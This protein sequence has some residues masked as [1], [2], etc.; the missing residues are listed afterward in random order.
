MIRSSDTMT[1]SAL[2]GRRVG[3]PLKALALL[4]VGVIALH[5]LVLHGLAQAL[6]AVQPAFASGPVFTTRT[7][8]LEA[9]RAPEAPRTVPEP[10]Q[11]NAHPPQEPLPAAVQTPQARP[12]E[13]PSRETPAAEPVVLQ[14]VSDPIPVTVLAQRAAEAPASGQTPAIA[15]GA[16]PL[17]A[18]GGAVTAS[19][20]QPD[21]DYQ[22]PGSSRLK[23]KGTG[24]K[25][26]LS[27]PVAAEL[28]WSREGR[29]YDARLEL[30]L[31]GFARV[32]TSK[33]V[34]GPRGLEPLRFGD[35]TRSEEAA[36][37]QRAK[38]IV[39]FSAN[40]PD[41][42]LMP[43]A[44]DLL[45]IYVQLASM[46][47]ANPQRFRPGMQLPFQL[48]EKHR[49]GNRVFTVGA[50]ERLKVEGRE[51]VATRLVC[52]PSAD[53]DNR[54]EVW[55]A[56]ALEYLPARIRMTQANGDEVDIFWSSSEK[57]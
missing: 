16:N 52:D 47:S 10:T 27:L 5:A 41:A 56:P 44:Q 31:L 4:V 2:P 50:T 30:G 33:G 20:G 51:M 54:V 21:Y 19:A 6:A 29:A 17:P 14:E 46:W 35:K 34:V 13:T 18:G 15:P 24:T 8:V 45:S 48:V 9:P 49:S 42:P 25:G 39:S 11:P 53:Y 40:G 57:P 23:Y 36:H 12:P 26:F 28:L 43:L 7:V 3:S 37:F 55:L 38:G 32:Q 1:P 22:V